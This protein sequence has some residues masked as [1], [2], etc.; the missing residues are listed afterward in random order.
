MIS[1]LGWCLCVF[2]GELG[3]GIEWY[4][5]VNCGWSVWSCYLYFFFLPVHRCSYSS[6]LLL[7][8]SILICCLFLSQ[9][10]YIFSHSI[11]QHINALH[12]NTYNVK[13]VC[14]H[15]PTVFHWIPL[16]S[17]SSC[18]AVIYVRCMLTANCSG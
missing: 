17:I 11:S 6:L 12:N 8:R 15:L 16:Y 13:C 18:V 5:S 9:H 1:L 7:L 3:G 10:S 4:K 2:G 14:L